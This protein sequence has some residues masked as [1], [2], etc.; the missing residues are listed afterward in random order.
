MKTIKQSVNEVTFGKQRTHMQLHPQTRRGNP[1]WRKESG[2]I[3][4]WDKRW[5]TEVYE[6]IEKIVLCLGFTIRVR[7][8]SS[9]VSALLAIIPLV[10]LSRQHATTNPDRLPRRSGY[11]IYSWPGSV[12]DVW[13][14]RNYYYFRWKREIAMIIFNGWARILP[15]WQLQCAAWSDSSVKVTAY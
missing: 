14:F 8:T 4:F 6:K 15:L 5:T 7:R 10:T 13:C 1:K 11:F 3:G 9:C 12:N 2:K